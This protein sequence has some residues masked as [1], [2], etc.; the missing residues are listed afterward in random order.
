MEEQ[1]NVKMFLSAAEI[2]AEKLPGLPDSKRGVLFAAERSGWATRPRAGRGGGIE[3]A[4]DSLPPAARA[5]YVG[6]HIEA[7]EV[8]ASVARDAAAEPGAVNVRGGAANARDAR[9]ALLAQ[10]DQIATTASI[11]H[12]RADLHFCD[13][14]NT[15][16]LELAGWI[17]AEVGHLTPRTLARWRAFAKAGRP[18]PGTTDAAC[19]RSNPTGRYTAGNRPCSRTKSAGDRK[20]G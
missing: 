19:T 12:K 7:V 8:P 16:Q 15:A 11:G 17:R 14:Y 6:R 1:P 9:L 3:Y 10:A 4:V 2:A 20:A 18:C 13:L 5:A